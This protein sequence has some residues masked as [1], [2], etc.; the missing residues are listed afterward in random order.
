MTLV[1]GVHSGTYRTA[2]EVRDLDSGAVRARAVQPHAP[3]SPPRCEEH[4]DAWWAAFQAAWAA[5]GAPTVAAISVAGQ[6]HG[7]VVLDDAGDVIRPAKL[8]PD[9]ETAPDAG[10]LAKQLPGGVAE[11]AS[12]AGSVP[13]AA[14]TIA[15]LSWLHRSEP[16]HWA[17]VARV[18]L[19]H[20]WLTHRLCEAFVT[21][22]GDA[23]G[24][25]YWSPSREAYRF[26]LLAVVDRDRDWTGVV[27]RV[28]L[29]DEVVGEWRGARVA[30]GTGE[31]MA[32]ALGLGLAE[33]TAALFPGMA[34]TPASAPLSDPSGAVAG[35]ADATGRYL[36]LARTSV[37]G[38][39]TALTTDEV[40]RASLDALDALRGV[41]PVGEV[42]LSAD[43]VRSASD[44]AVAAM[45]DLSVRSA[46]VEEPAAAGACVQAAAVAS[47]SSHLDVVDAWGLGRHPTVSVGRAR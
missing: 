36:P 27:P 29:P 7:L 25:G 2:V 9:I 35:F 43:W 23:S 5:V 13:T 22:R 37:G 18:L 20:D 42:V 15:K 26:E 12:A 4:P 46:A 47:D 19:P 8:W 11:W 41:V 30:C 31:P 44:S 33:G 38:D 14:F 1:A 40:V 39:I 17:R 16:E 28:A 3:T 32:A 10:W 34:F 21:D 45:A 24:T 6:P